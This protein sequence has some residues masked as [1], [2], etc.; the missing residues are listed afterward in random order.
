MRLSLVATSGEEAFHG[1]IF[2]KILPMQPFTAIADPACFPLGSC[3]IEEAWKPGEGDA[4][5]AAVIQFHPHRV[6]VESDRF[7]FS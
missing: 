6:G 1:D 5:R 4:K 7:G 2:V 3:R